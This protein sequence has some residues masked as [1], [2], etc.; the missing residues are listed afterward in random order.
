MIR[1]VMHLVRTV[2]LSDEM[3]VVVETTDVKKIDAIEPANLWSFFIAQE[4]LPD[5]FEEV[6]EGVEIHLGEYD[7]DKHGNLPVVDSTAPAPAIASSKNRV[8]ALSEHRPDL[9]CMAVTLTRYVMRFEFIRAIV[10]GPTLDSINELDADELWWNC[11]KSGVPIEIAEQREPEISIEYETYLPDKHKH[12]P[13]VTL[14]ESMDSDNGS[15][16]LAEST[17]W[18]PSTTAKQKDELESGRVGDMVNV[19][20]NQCYFNARRVIRSLP[21][22]SDA[23]YVEGFVVTEKGACFEHGWIVKDGMI[24]DPTLPYGDDSYFSALEFAGQVGIRQFLSTHIGN[25]YSN[26]PFHQAFGWN[27]GIECQNF[28]QAFKTAMKHLSSEFGDREVEEAFRVRTIKQLPWT[29]EWR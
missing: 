22:Y 25:K 14:P 7:P 26:R 10:Q 6:D 23:T 20:A 28:R 8:S 3:Q 27:P 17:T 9:I 21:D 18:H 13:F 15:C 1:K 29:D 4:I 19:Q 11:S 5:V 2:E 24:V 16:T 12:L